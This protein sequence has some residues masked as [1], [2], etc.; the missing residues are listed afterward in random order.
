[1]LRVALCQSVPCR[2]KSKNPCLDLSCQP[3]QLHVPCRASHALTHMPCQACR[4]CSALLVVLCQLCRAFCAWLALRA[5]A[6]TVQ[7]HGMVD[8]QLEPCQPC[9][10]HAPCPYCPCHAV[11]E[12]CLGR[13]SRVVWC[14]LVRSCC[15]CDMVNITVRASAVPC[16]KRATL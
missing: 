9:Q 3:C 11:L 14:L 2:A 12:S 13:A 5:I 8:R 16:H 15:D 1:M 4:A 10:A 7:F 6:F